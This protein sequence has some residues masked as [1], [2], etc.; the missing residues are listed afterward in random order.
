MMALI[1]KDSEQWSDFVQKLIRSKQKSNRDVLC[2]K[3]WR[4]YCYEQNIHH[5]LHNPQHIDHILTSKAFCSESKFVAIATA[6]NKM[7]MEND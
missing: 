4:I 7:R 5:K 1:A 2:V 3:C 6:L